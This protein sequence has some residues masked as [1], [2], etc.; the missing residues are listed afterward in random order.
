MTLGLV[1]AIVQI[2]NYSLPKWQAV[3]LTLHPGG[4]GGRVLPLWAI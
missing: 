4:G 1:H 2:V 3:Q